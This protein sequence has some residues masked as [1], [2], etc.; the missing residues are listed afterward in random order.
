MGLRELRLAT[1]YLALAPAYQRRFMVRPHVVVEWIEDERRIDVGSV[2]LLRSALNL[3][4]QSAAAST[5]LRARS[6][7]GTRSWTRTLQIRTCTRKRADVSFEGLSGSRMLD[8]S[9]TG[10]DPE[11]KSQ[12]KTV[13]TSDTDSS[14]RIRRS[15]VR[16]S[17][18]A[19]R[20]QALGRVTSGKSGRCSIRVLPWSV[21]GFGLA[22]SAPINVRSVD[23]LRLTTPTQKVARWRL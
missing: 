19:P 11:Q 15:G 2:P 23:Q 20:L 16:I 4:A 3:W 6:A 13:R 7:S 22:D 12:T 5:G 1:I 21:T 9:I 17:S 18:G 8:H 14:L 10:F